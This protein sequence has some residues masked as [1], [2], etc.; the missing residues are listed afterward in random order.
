MLART[1][2]LVLLGIPTLASAGL[3]G[4]VAPYGIHARE[5]ATAGALGAFTTDFTGAISN[6]ASLAQQGPSEISLG[7]LYS[8][9][10][11]QLGG[12]GVAASSGNVAVFGI[13]LDLSSLTE[14]KTPI[15]FAL[16]LALDD[17][18]GTL[19]SLSDAGSQEGQFL[20]EGRSQ[21]LLVPAVG[22]QIFPWLRVGGGAEVAVTASAALQF[23]TTLDG[24]TSNQTMSM[25]GGSALAPE[26]GVMLGPWDV[27][28][29]Q[30]LSVA[31]SYH[32]GAWYAL[33]VDA[34]A[35]ATVGQSP[36]TTLPLS[37]KFIDAYRPNQVSVAARAAF[38]K[39]DVGATLEYGR[40]SALGKLL[41]TQDI[42]RSSAALVFSD[43]ITPKVGVEVHVLPGL[44]G[45]AGY[46][47]KPSPLQDP[48]A[49]ALNAVDNTRHLFALGAGYTLPART[50]ILRE[51]LS[52]DAAYQLE[53]LA[54]REFTL[55]NADGS[56][57]QAM[58]GGM[59]HA[60]HATLTARF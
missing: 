48:T 33:A 51:P 19:L 25:H 45:R 42:V 50:F 56:T 57:R 17:N 47:F 53:L 8:R 18:F 52:I 11:L 9:P 43:V 54:G 34:Q 32:H 16:A 39:V 49:S 36:L 29:V 26:F 35:E 24:Q 10:N 37:M 46:A 31:A 60:L 7:Y 55:M 5:A 12:E 23:R 6:P 28:P 22:V 4:P 59:V 14:A 44:E 30:Q 13:K 27:G 40:W 58:A 1:L 15:G 41:A 2:A 3:M 38:G 21:L 20:R